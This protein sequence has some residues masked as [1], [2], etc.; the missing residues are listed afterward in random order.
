MDEDEMMRKAAA[1]SKRT[2]PFMGNIIPTN[3]SQNDYPKDLSITIEPQIRLKDVMEE[4]QKGPLLATIRS[5]HTPSNFHPPS[6]VGIRSLTGS[7]ASSSGFGFRD[8]RV[9]GGVQTSIIRTDMKEAETQFNTV[10]QP[11]TTVDPRDPKAEDT[12]LFPGVSFYRMIP[13]LKY[14]P[15]AYSAMILTAVFPPNNF[16]GDIFIDFQITGHKGGFPMYP[17]TPATFVLDLSRVSAVPQ[18]D[19]PW[20]CIFDSSWDHFTLTATAQISEK[21]ITLK[22]Q[23]FT[24]LNLTEHEVNSL[25]EHPGIRSDPSAKGYILNPLSTDLLHEREPTKRLPEYDEDDDSSNDDYVDVPGESMTTHHEPSFGYQ[26]KQKI[27]LKD[28]KDYGS[29]APNYGRKNHPELQ[30]YSDQEINDMVNNKS[31]TIPKKAPPEINYNYPPN[32]QKYKN[33]EYVPMNQLPKFSY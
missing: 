25:D 21:R 3:L 24:M 23:S 6:S 17:V 9:D 30:K 5:N 28:V 33:G 7:M 2:Q 31:R 29:D 11:I 1:L 16:W 18:F 4:E 8:H 19:L 20:C 32:V 13:L 12:I 22:R 26:E 10:L 27:T 15:K 14:G